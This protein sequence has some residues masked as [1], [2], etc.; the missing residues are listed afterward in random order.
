M[1]SRK[2]SQWNWAGRASSRAGA[3]GGWLGRSLALPAAMW[4]LVWCVN[5]NAQIVTGSNGSDGALNPTTNIVINMAD[6][7]DGIYQYTSVNI[8][9][10]V[11][12]TFIP[13]AN[14]TSVVWLVQTNVV[15][16][17]IVDVSGQSGNATIGG[18]GGPGGWAGG[19]GGSLPSSGQGPGAGGA[20]TTNSDPTGGCASFGSAG[21]SGNGGGFAGQL[22]GNS[23][24]I[25]LLGGSG[26][27]G[28][29]WSDGG[30]GGGGER[31]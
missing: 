11:T 13:N 5:A 25:P 18:A 12:V 7:P 24:L 9:N 3:C 21:S 23:F 8:S 15:I 10:G 27:G 4:V 17:G 6:H 19:S 28:T 26:G 2:H 1:N 16:N 30:G 20:S 22:Y 31:S 14:N 29:V